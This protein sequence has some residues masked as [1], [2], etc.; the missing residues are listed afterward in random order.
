[1]VW[2]KEQMGVK[3]HLMTLRGMSQLCPDKTVLLRIPCEEGW[4]PELRWLIVPVTEK[5]DWI[6]QIPGWTQENSTGMPSLLEANVQHFLQTPLTVLVEISIHNGRVLSQPARSRGCLQPEQ[7]GLSC[8][9]QVGRDSRPCL[10]ALNHGLVSSTMIVLHGK[11]QYACR[12]PYKK[13]FM[14]LLVFIKYLMC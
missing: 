2:V 5:P 9:T 1:M 13:I 10:V 8:R 7:W 11:G 14:S 6:F 12:V 4:G 3:L